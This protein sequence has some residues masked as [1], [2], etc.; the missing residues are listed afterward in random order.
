MYYL[1][2]GKELTQKVELLLRSSSFYL[3]LSIYLYY[4]Y[5]FMRDLRRYALLH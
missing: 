4:Y 1:P 3:S 5:A 2:V